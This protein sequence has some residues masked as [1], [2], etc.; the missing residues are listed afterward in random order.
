MCDL[1]QFTINSIDSNIKWDYFILESA[2]HYTMLYMVVSNRNECCNSL[3]STDSV[4]G[5][6]V[7]VTGASSGIGEE[8]AYTYARHGANL[9][10]TARREDRLKQ[11]GHWYNR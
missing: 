5:L 8:L 1:N 10:I 6:N 11:V 9:V 3:F 7:L 2:S 4:S